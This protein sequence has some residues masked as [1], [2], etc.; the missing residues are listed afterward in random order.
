MK[1]KRQVTNVELSIK[2]RESGITKP[3]L[4]FREW[5]GAKE[6]EISSFKNN[7]AWFYIDGVNCYTVSELFDYIYANT[8]TSFFIYHNAGKYL[9]QFGMSEGNY[10]D[11][12]L[13]NCLAMYILNNKFN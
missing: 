5:T 2:L 11:E 13:A 6:E 1:L 7:K 8:K 9:L 3:S 12:N 4:F 10:E